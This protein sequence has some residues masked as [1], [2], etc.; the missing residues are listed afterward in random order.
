MRSKT[1]GGQRRRVTV[2]G[3][4]AVSSATAPLALLAS[5]MVLPVQSA[6]ADNMPS[7]TGLAGDNLWS[8]AGNWSDS[9]VPTTGDTVT[10]NASAQNGVATLATVSFSNNA[11]TQLNFINTASTQINSQT[12]EQNLVLSDAGSG[13]GVNTLTSH[14]TRGGVTFGPLVVSQTDSGVFN[15]TI[16]G[17]ISFINNSAFLLGVNGAVANNCFQAGTANATL[18]IDGTGNTFIGGAIASNASNGTTISLI[19]N[20]SGTLEMDGNTTQNLTGG[21]TIN[22]GQVNI[23]GSDTLGVSNNAVTLNGGG[24]AALGAAR[25]IPSSDHLTIGGNVSFGGQTGNFGLTFGSGVTL[26]GG[27][28][29]LTVLSTLQFNGSISNGTNGNGF[30]KMGSAQL[31]LNSASSNYSGPTTVGQGTLAVSGAATDILSQ[32]SDFTV[33]NGATLSLAGFS[34]V[35]G[36]LAGGGSVTTGNV[37]AAQITMGG[38][39]ASTTFS[40]SITGSGTGGGITKNGTGTFVLSGSDSNGGGNGVTVNGGVFV[41]SNSGGTALP[42]VPALAVKSATFQI[43]ASSQQINTAVTVALSSGTVDLNGFSQTIG[44]LAGDANSSVALGGGTLT[45]G[46]ASSTIYSGNIADAGG[47]S[48]ARAAR[49]L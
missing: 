41:A 1:I 24:L 30:T 43:G 22:A 37:G 2:R 34:Q 6:K 49:S 39:N 36:S 9:L 4:I 21:I 15:F 19:K 38:D 10:F 27:T 32:N 31:T 33:S 18:T 16:N 45:V 3:L 23:K 46:G 35:I 44:S 28:P 17:N 26:D 20:G 7:W 14:Q 12:A 8:T 42:N 5:A 29:T 11:A 40:G 25:T 13:G 48:A 47:A